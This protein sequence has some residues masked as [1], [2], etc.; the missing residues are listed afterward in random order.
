MHPIALSNNELSSLNVGE[1]L[2]IATV[3]LVFTVV[4]LTVV[5]Y[6]LFVAKSGKVTLPSGYKFEW[7]S[8]KNAALIC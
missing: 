2:T 8:A 3:M 6:R 1:A 4:I 7:A 5:A